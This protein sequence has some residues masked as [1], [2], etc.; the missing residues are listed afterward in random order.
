MLDHNLQTV[1]PEITAA[2]Q[3]MNNG[4]MDEKWPYLFWKQQSQFIWPQDV[5]SL[6]LKH[7]LQRKII[8]YLRGRESILGMF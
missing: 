1:K 8:T 7:H 2:G 3:T 6:T 4:M 5:S